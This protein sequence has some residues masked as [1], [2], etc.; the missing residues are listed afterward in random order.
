MIDMDILD[1]MGVS[2]LSAKV[3]VKSELL[4][5]IDILI[6]SECTSSLYVVYVVFK[7]HK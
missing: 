2:K 1:D 3:F 4:M 5:E 6:A 7:R